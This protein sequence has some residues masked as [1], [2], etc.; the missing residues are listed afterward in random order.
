MHKL[1]ELFEFSS[2]GSEIR[3][4]KKKMS[5]E[6]R[7]RAGESTTMMMFVESV[8]CALTLKY[9]CSSCLR[10]DLDMRIIVVDV[11]II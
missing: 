5:D 2:F 1:N 7:E 10:F 11:V 8:L 6:K 3:R 4:T 9:S